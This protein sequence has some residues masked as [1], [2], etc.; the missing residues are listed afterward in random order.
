MW[1]DSKLRHELSGDVEVQGKKVMVAKTDQQG[2]F[3][4]QEAGEVYLRAC[5]RP[6]K[7]YQTGSE[8]K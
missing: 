6:L 2:Q 8:G 4:R 5:A 1:W 7:R 3:G